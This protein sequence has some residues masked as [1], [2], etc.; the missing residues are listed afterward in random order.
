MERNNKLR[1]LN[2]VS[3]CNMR[4]TLAFAFRADY[5]KELALLHCFHC[6]AI[7]VLKIHFCPCL[8]QNVKQSVKS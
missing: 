7:C 6:F 8:R 4:Y 1:N 5:P 2:V 3:E